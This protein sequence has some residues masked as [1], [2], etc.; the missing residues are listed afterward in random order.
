MS[1]RF[2]KSV[3]GI[4]VFGT[5]I[6]V[7]G[8]A[9]KGGVNMADYSL[10]HKDDPVEVRK[11]GADRYQVLDYRSY[12]TRNLLLR[13]LL[14]DSPSYEVV[15]AADA[16]QELALIEQKVRTI[17]FLENGKAVVS[18]NERHFT[19]DTMNIKLQND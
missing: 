7:M 2:F 13:H 6:G 8:Y 18:M 17:R 9:F 12:D 15:V 11:I 1:N 16:E 3:M 19:R 4:T 10:E 14:P 5:L